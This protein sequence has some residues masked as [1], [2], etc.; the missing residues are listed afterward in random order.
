VLTVAEAFGSLGD[1]NVVVQALHIADALAAHDAS[2][3]AQRRV[4]AVRTR[5]LSDPA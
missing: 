1:T 5:L 2:G 4:V 3:D